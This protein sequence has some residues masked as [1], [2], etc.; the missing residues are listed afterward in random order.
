M[1]GRSKQLK[2][3]RWRHQTANLFLTCGHDREHPGI[4]W[5]CEREVQFFQLK[6]SAGQLKLTDGTIS[7]PAVLCSSTLHCGR[8]RPIKLARSANWF[9][10]TPNRKEDMQSASLR[11]VPFILWLVKILCAHL[12]NKMEDTRYK[13]SIQSVLSVS[14]FATNRRN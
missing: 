6:N 13:Y 10:K 4:D 11:G 1:I 5:T 3:T 12:Y 2:Q 7:L 14:L 9:L 8:G